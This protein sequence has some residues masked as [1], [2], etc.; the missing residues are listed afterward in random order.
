[1]NEVD[2]VACRAEL[3]FL[4]RDG[5]YRATATAILHRKGYPRLRL[6]DGRAIGPGAC[7]WLTAVR[8]ASEEELLDMVVTANRLPDAML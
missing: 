1:M 4:I 7:S 3:A 5:G 8:N 2:D 6:G